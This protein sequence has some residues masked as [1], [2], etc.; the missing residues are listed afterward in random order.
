MKI[1]SN[2]RVCIVGYTG[3]GKSIRGQWI[4]RQWLGTKQHIFIFDPLNSWPNWEGVCFTGADV[5]RRV[6]NGF[7]LHRLYSTNPEDLDALIA[8]ARS[9]PNSLLIVDES[10]GM[11]SS[12]LQAN[13]EDY[14]QLINQ[15]RRYN[16]TM[17]QVAQYFTDLPPGLRAQAYIFLANMPEGGALKWARER[18]GG[19]KPPAIPKFCWLVVSPDGQCETISPLTEIELRALTSERITET[20]VRGSQSPRGE[21]VMAEQVTPLR[22]VHNRFSRFDFGSL[23]EG[24]N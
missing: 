3:S 13:S 20:M 2:A 1:P 17:I 9:A 18:L 10:S 5:A 6:M 23:F 21:P 14:V 12:R 15:G 7:R 11:F 4:A 16:Q 24:E 22:P 19:E 8:L